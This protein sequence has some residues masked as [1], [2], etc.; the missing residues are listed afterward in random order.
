MLVNKVKEHWLRKKGTDKLYTWNKILAQRDDMEDISL[1]E[2]ETFKEINIKYQ[3]LNKSIND[4]IKDS[5]KKMED[6]MINSID[7]VVTLES[8]P[9]DDLKFEFAPED[10]GNDQ[11]ENDV[12]KKHRHSNEPIKETLDTINNSLEELGQKPKSKRKPVVRR[13]PAPKAVN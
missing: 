7:N 6:K 11:V 2:V 10:E 5:R 3:N 13:R 8:V 4:R 12:L 1:E 9:D